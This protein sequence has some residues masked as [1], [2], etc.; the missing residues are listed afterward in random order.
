MFA[1]FALVA[2]ALFTARMA[3][4][5]F[6]LRSPFVKD[7]DSKPADNEEHG[8]CKRTPLDDVSPLPAL[9]LYA[10]DEPT[11]GLPGVNA[12]IGG[13]NAVLH[14]VVFSPCKTDFAL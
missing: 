1:P 10:R 5:A 11:V 2:Y 3:T 13:V 7:S 9:R 12:S 6:H 14:S 4:A 8:V